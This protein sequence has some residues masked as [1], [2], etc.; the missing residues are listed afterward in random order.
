[1]Y[2]LCNDCFCNIIIGELEVVD[3]ICV[4]SVNKTT[5]SDYQLQNVKIY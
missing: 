1:M 4:L 3:V 5:G 2:L